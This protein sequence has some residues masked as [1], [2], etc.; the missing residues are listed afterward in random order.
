MSFEKEKAES[1][2]DRTDRALRSIAKKLSWSDGFMIVIEDKGEVTAS[3]E[4]RV[5]YSGAI[6][7]LKAMITE[8]SRVN[9]CS[10]TSIMEEVKGGD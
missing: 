2:L 1:E 6:K 9:G 4:E 8:V 3:S 7:M 10:I 5:T